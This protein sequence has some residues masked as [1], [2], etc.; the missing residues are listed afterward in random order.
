MEQVY[1]ITKS[2]LDQLIKKIEIEGDD[3]IAIKILFEYLQGEDI[4]LFLHN[5][6]PF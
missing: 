2:Q 3:P 4:K 1:I 6:L 5:Q